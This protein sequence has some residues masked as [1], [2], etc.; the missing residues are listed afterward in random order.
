MKYLWIKGHQQRDR[1]EW[2]K[3]SGSR[4]ECAEFR[5]RRRGNVQRDRF[6]QACLRVI[7]FFWVFLLINQ[8][9]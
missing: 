5:R 2:G 1:L 9:T 8:M 7:A 4:P 3:P 6:A